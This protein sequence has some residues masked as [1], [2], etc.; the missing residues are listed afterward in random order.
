M[1]KFYIATLLLFSAASFSQQKIVPGTYISTNEGQD[2][3]LKLTDDKKFEIVLFHGDYEIK[4]DTIN[5][6][7][8]STSNSE[9][10]VSISSNAN[11]SPGKVKVLL[12]G[13]RASLYAEALYIGTQN[14]KATPVFKNVSEFDSEINYDEDELNFEI[15]RAD[16]FYL[17]KED[18]YDKSTIEKYSLPRSS[19]EITFEYQPNYFGSIKL[20][21]Y[22]ND[23]NEFVVSEKS[24]KNPL[25]FIEESK[26]KQAVKSNVFPVETKSERNWTY[27]GKKVNDQ[28]SLAVDT[29]MMAS[30]YK[31]IIQDNLQKAIDATKKTP[32]KF[33]VIS[34]DPDTKN[35]KASFDEF[36]TNQQYSIGTYA[37]YEYGQMKNEYDNFNYYHAS[38][39]DKTW[40]SKN[41]ISDIPSTI[42][43]DSDGN[44]LGKAKGNLT[45]NI[46]FFDVYSSSIFNNLNTVKAMS[47]LNKSL[48]SKAKDAVILKKLVPLSKENESAW[49][50]YP[51]VSAT[52]SEVQEVTVPV[53]EVTTE[54]A[55][56]TAMA[57]SDFYKQ[58]ELVYTKVNFDKKKLL[59][60]WE[61]V[62]KSH[63]K[64]LKP[65]M[66]FVT[67]AQAEIQN[68]GFYFQI[69][70]E[71]R[72]YDETN[73][74]AID[75]LL[76][77]YDAISEMQQKTNVDSLAMDFG[78]NNYLTI[79]T[80][81][82]NAIMENSY[83]VTPETPIEYQKRLLEIYKKILEKQDGSARVAILY[84]S[85]LETFAR[86]ANSEKEYVSEYDNFFAKTFKGTN[87]IEVL[88]ELFS[89]ANNVDYYGDWQGF[90]IAYASASNEA[91]WFVVEKSNNPKSIKKA[92]KWSESSLRI[93][94]NSPYY[95]DTLA[96]LYYK[97]GEKQKAIVT[98]EMALKYAIDIEE[99]TRQ[100]LE[101]VLE[102]M[103]NGTY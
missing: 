63:S 44:I 94:K 3:K 12:K 87:E 32:S 24:K 99:N 16:F 42:I 78:S 68:H 86:N 41:K 35:G 18:S 46:Y 91:A 13:K 37:S 39:K 15:D 20:V 27:A 57:Y 93:E 9:F 62:V 92:I 98:Q 50:I 73:F 95:L 23:K 76:K 88:D 65:D 17:V 36:I 58:N 97:N 90:K 81:L 25:I 59:A 48:N 34:Y 31:L 64:D 11:P 26:K 10:L 83:L 101:N 51:P 96:Q 19:N 80:I 61:S 55:V 72:L 56:D 53:E 28:T 33:L 77:H 43:L 49:S 84:F 69:F 66:D 5:F 40:A 75:Y 100:D 79:E 8:S 70:N 29:T 85:N 71:V 4:N 22:Y 30:N 14:G 102:K 67:V 1:N 60:A 52:V 54:V 38:A 89:N 2:V 45:E 82:P 74:K 47:E 7:N 103:K 21:G 6:N